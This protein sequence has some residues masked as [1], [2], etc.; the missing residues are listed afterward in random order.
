[1]LGGGEGGGGRRA[2]MREFGWWVWPR[3]DSRSWGQIAVIQL[4]RRGCR[5]WL[6]RRCEILVRAWYRPREVRYDVD[7][8]PT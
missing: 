4:T 7:I 5:L 8:V 1:M 6:V 2:W 3:E